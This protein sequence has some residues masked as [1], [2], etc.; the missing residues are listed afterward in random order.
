MEKG[1]IQGFFCFI[2]R[3]K[4]AWNVKTA[5]SEK[6]LKFKKLKFRNF[7]EILL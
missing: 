5:I 4:T 7:S 1:R 3:N 6:F 2:L